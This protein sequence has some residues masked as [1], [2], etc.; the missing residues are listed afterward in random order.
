M[1]NTQAFEDNQAQASAELDA[2]CEVLQA[3]RD[4]LMRGR[5]TALIAAEG[6]IAAAARVLSTASFH[7]G[8]AY[9]ALATS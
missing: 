9:A 3:A 6:Q 8:L 4:N 5:L 1:T 2:A 7:T